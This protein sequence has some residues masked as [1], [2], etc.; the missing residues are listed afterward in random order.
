MIV[1]SNH[2]P[3]SLSLLL[4]LFH[5]S[6]VLSI[7]GSPVLCQSTPFIP[8]HNLAGEGY[9]MVTMRRQGAYVIDV[10]TYLNS[11][12]SCELQHNPL[13]GNKLQKAPL[14]VVDWRSYSRCA[15]NLYSSVHT[16]ISSL[17]QKYTDQDSTEWKLG[18]DFSKFGGLDVGGTRSNAYSFASSRTRED[19]HSFS[20]HTITCSHYSYRLSNRPPLSSEFQRDLASLPNS[21]TPSTKASYRLIIA[22][23]GTHYI[24]KVYLGGRYRQFSAIR[25]CL[26]T[27]NGF[28]SSQAHSCLSLGI[29][30]GLG[31]ISL[32]PSVKTCSNV[33]ENRDTATSSSS[34]LH[35]HLSEVKGGTGWM[36]EIALTHNNSV[37][38]QDWLKTLKDHPDIVQYTLRPLYDLVPKMSQNVGLKA[39][40]HDYLKENGIKS[41]TA[42]LNCGSSYPNLDSSCCPRRSRKGNLMVTIVRAWGLK[43]DL[44]GNT[45]AYV[46]MWYANH[47]RRTHMI[48]SNYPYWNSRYYLGNVDTHLGLRIEVWDKDVRFDDLLGSCVRYLSRGTHRF[49]C[50]AKNGGIEIQYTLTCDRHLTGN[51]CQQYR[52][53]P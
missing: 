20:I 7:P 12:G 32:S 39:A 23:Y 45:E 47:Y 34:G 40:I 11:N 18:L 25:T 3:L 9:N 46:K 35:Q 38:F 48:R 50:Y 44:I 10:K 28:T 43:G 31:K 5:L 4:L 52:P 14:S 51:Q 37:G 15:T 1:L 17:L 13:Q 6:S 41:S 8:G 29:R 42:S 26:S 30:L 22:T 19:R 49:T 36:G 2:A 33:L 16:S 27:L 53:T 24:N 21:Y